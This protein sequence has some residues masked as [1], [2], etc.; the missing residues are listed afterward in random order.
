MARPIRILAI[1][2]HFKT[3]GDKV[4][5]S[6]V[7]AARIVF[8]MTELSKNPDFEVKIVKDPFKDNNETWESLTKYYDIIY[9]SY[10]DSPEGYINMKVNADKNNC[11]VV[12]DCDDNMF[13]VP[14][15]SP[16][17][18]TY[19]YGSFPLDVVAKVLEDVEVMTTTNSFLKYE[20]IEMCKKRPEQVKVLPNFIDLKMY[21]KDNIKPKDDDKIVIS[22]HGSNTHVVDLVMPEFF[23]GI[24]RIIKEFPNVEFKTTG[25]FLPHLKTAM[26]SQYKFILGHADV[27]SWASELWPKMM[28]NTDI[29]VAPLVKSDFSK[30]KSGIK[31]LENSAAMKPGVYEDIRQYQEFYRQDSEAL[32]LAETEYDWYRQLKKLVENEQL[33]KD[34]GKRAYDLVRSKHQMKD[35]IHLY[36]DFFKSLVR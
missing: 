2:T 13:K 25:L 6:G 31:F 5:T 22:F 11:K 4:V 3:N 23:N 14:K 1:E 16:V 24:T 20:F 28:Q 17:Y 33:R 29:V 12:V 26:G 8:P 7:D 32:L 34:M 10:I 27:N 18:E 36:A 21:N 15:A 9:S 30:S 35:N 19:H